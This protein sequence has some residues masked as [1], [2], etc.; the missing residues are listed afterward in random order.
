[1]IK[2]TF[3]QRLRTLTDTRGSLCVGIDPHPGL[4][5]QWG[6]P[7]DVSGLERF[8]DTVVEALADRVAVLKP[9]SAFFERFGSAGVAV[10][11]RV[12]AQAREG[13][14][15]TIVD[16]KRGDIGSTM[17]AY[18]QAYVGEGSPLAG[19]AVTVSPY[20]GFES[21]RPL[22][23]LAAQTGRGVFVLALT[24]NPEGADVQHAR[25]A[26]GRTVAQAVI[27]AAATENAGAVP[28][29]S[30]GVV[31]GATV[32]GVGREHTF[33]GLN[34]PLLAPGIGAQG[35]TAAD[36]QAVFGSALADVLPSSSRAGR[37]GG[38]TV[39]GLRAAAE[40]AVDAVGAVLAQAG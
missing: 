18:A 11:E 1:V 13:G 3:G 34:G 15:L 4:L 28:L 6:L 31:V 27:D 24:S 16:A 5:A 2:G 22:L 10:L 9:Q 20:L 30:V 37:A 35:A 21:L 33:A 40:R 32:T 36:L 29:G 8:A 17:A 14:A 19:D 25:S 12:I 7:D 39:E 26:D 38:P 23:D